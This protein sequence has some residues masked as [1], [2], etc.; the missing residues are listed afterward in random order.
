METSFSPTKLLESKGSDNSDSI[1]DN[2]LSNKQ[3]NDAVIVV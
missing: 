2:T 3:N 1:I